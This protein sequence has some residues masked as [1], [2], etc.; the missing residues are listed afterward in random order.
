VAEALPRVCAGGEIPDIR[1]FTCDVC[2]ERERRKLQEAV[3]ER[4]EKKSHNFLDKLLT[5]GAAKGCP[6]CGEVIEKNGGCNHMECQQCKA[7]FCWLCMELFATGSDVYEHFYDK[8]NKCVT[9][10]QNDGAEG[11]GD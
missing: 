8:N 11:Y 1:N 7:H 6:F 5:Q 2:R 4:E 3:E 9:F 10:S